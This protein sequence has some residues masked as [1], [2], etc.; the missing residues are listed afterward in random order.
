MAIQKEFK[1]LRG[2]SS[3]QGALQKESFCKGL[4]PHYVLAE[5]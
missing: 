1:P 3:D 2:W 4:S 5:A